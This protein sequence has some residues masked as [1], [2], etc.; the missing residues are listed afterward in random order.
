MQA[1][2]YRHIILWLAIVC[3]GYRVPAGEPERVETLGTSTVG[4]PVQIDQFVLPGTEL[5]VARQAG[6][7][8][9]IRLRIVAV[10]PHG[11]AFRYDL[12]YFGLDPGR[13][14]LRDYL[15]R[16]NG[17]TT[18]N[19]PSMP[20]DVTVMLPPGQVEPNALPPQASPRL[21]GYRFFLTVGAVVWVAGL[22]LLLLA[23]RRRHNRREEQQR[24]IT[25]EDR[26]RTVAT[27]AI[28]GPLQPS[29][30]A[31]LERL[32]LAYWQKRLALEKMKPGEAIRHLRE[33]QE[34]GP[35][36]AQLELWLHHP[37]ADTQIDLVPLLVPYCELR[38]EPDRV[39]SRTRE[40]DRE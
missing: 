39:V 31:E 11:D 5:E 8:V 16:K 34:A 12:E 14:D 18:D 26:L 17:S 10:Y 21:G 22:L 19:L 38:S 7:D 40:T 3:E 28:D 9:P 37:T 6:D 29:E 20:V 33:H 24:P 13:F 35:L 23:G 27:K 30:N 15:Q 1:V 32:L 2:R 36:F 25:L 4:M